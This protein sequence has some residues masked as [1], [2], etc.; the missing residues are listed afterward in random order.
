MK[1]FI[2]VYGCQMNLSDAERAAAVLEKAGWEK[3]AQENE[4]DLALFLACSVRSAAVNRLYG[5]GKKFK[6]YRKKN[7]NFRAVLSG[8]VTQTDQPRLRQVFDEI[9]DIKMIDT[10]PQILSLFKE[11]KDNAAKLAKEATDYFAIVP[12]HTSP[13]TAYVPIM[14]GCDN[15]CSYCIVPYTRGR[16]TSR[17]AEEI[18]QEITVLLKKGYK[19]IVLLGQNVNSYKSA[20]STDFPKLLRQI[21]NLPGDF[22]VSFLTSHPKDMSDELIKTV[23]NGKHLTPLI[24]LA[25]QS[26]SNRVLESMNRKYT[27]EHFLSLVKKIR[28]AIRPVTLTTD[29]IIGF[30]GETE[31]DL[32]A[33]AQVMREA[34]F[35]MAYLNKYSPRHGTVSAQLPD[36]ISWEEKKRRENVLNEILRATA[37]NNNQKYLNQKVRI[38]L[39]SE[40][41]E[42]F[43]GRTEGSKDIQIKKNA[44]PKLGLGNFYQAKITNSSAWAFQGEIVQ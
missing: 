30:P 22:W 38:L 43:F 35:D 24:H 42:S 32:A 11:K 13:F 34:Q 2:K 29:V 20:D 6:A 19:E 7:P 26:G 4:A 40:N 18:L 15:F 8:C 28:Q 23:A 39:L 21:N 1:Y 12:K 27:A 17:A 16:E 36:S 41:K 44:N 3:T 9:I 5:W 10:L 33:T 14:T 25:L 31:E 37:A